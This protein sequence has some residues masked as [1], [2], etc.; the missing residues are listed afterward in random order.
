MRSSGLIALCW[1]GGLG[2][3]RVGERGGGEC[4]AGGS[5]GAGECEGLV[6]EVF[7]GM[8]EF[9]LSM[10]GIKMVV[11]AD[12]VCWA[13]GN[14]LGEVDVGGDGEGVCDRVGVREYEGGGDQVRICIILRLLAEVSLIESMRSFIE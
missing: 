6:I 14:S 4:S 9:S 8:C 3:G 1:S 11:L 2:G 5:G 10:V 13:V 7:D 12:R